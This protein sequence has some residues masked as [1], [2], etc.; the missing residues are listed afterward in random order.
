MKL[1]EAKSMVRDATT[2]TE[3]K[4][5]YS[6]NP[7]NTT[8]AITSVTFLATSGNLDDGDALIYGVK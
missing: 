5:R 6:I 1:V 4:F 8:N 2:P 3:V 7:V